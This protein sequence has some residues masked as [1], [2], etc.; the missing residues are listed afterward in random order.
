MSERLRRR[1]KVGAVLL[2]ASLVL[3]ACTSSHGIFQTPTGRPSVS[4]TTKPSPTSHPTP[5]LPPPKPNLHPVRGK[6][7]RCFVGGVALAPHIPIN[8]ANN[9]NGD[10]AIKPTMPP[11]LQSKVNGATVRIHVSESDGTQY[12]GTGIGVTTTGLPG[13]WIGTAAHLGYDTL[14]LK[15][16]TTIDA[17]NHREQPDA[18]CFVYN[19][20]ENGQPATLNSRATRTSAQTIDDIMFLHIPGSL[21]NTLPLAAN[22]PTY[23]QPL[24]FGGYPVVNGHQQAIHYSHACPRVFTRDD[25]FATSC[26][27]APAGSL[28]GNSGAGVVTASGQVDGIFYGYATQS[29][30]F[31]NINGGVNLSHPATE[32]VYNGLPVMSAALNAAEQ[33]FEI[34]Q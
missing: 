10:T 16:F 14:S 19:N 1:S 6:L 33:Q 24:Y 27:T 8:P 11:T 22:E 17:R 7:V 25:T 13:T 31:W 21:P 30:I 28:A 29:T 9:I 3:E 20:N 23:G 18:G 26:V 2:V 34:L 5:E 15:D 4:Q 32:I 12:D